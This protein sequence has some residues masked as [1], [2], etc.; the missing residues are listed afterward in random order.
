MARNSWNTERTD[1][2]NICARDILHVHCAR[3]GRAS[4]FRL[5]TLIVLVTGNMPTNFQGDWIKNKVT[6]IASI[7]SSRARLCTWTTG[8]AFQL[9]SPNFVESQGWSLETCLQSFKQ[10][11]HKMESQW[12]LQNREIARALRATWSREHLHTLHT[13]S[14]SH[15][16]HAY[17]F[18]RRLD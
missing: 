18:S 2:A 12:K 17:K 6:V 14:T 3:R 13:G 5:C 1:L 9:A 7:F 11:G 16:Q 8:A 15:R 10:I 4:T